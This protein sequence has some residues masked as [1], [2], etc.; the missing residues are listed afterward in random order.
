[1]KWL[2]LSFYMI[3]ETIKYF[4]LTYG[5]LG[6]DIRKGKKKYLIAIVPMIVVPVQI[7]FSMDT[8]EFRLIWGLLFLLAFFK[9][10]ILKKVQGFVIECMLIST[11]DLMIW[12]IYIVISGS[13]VD[14]NSFASQRLSEFICVILF[15]IFAFVLRKSRK[16]IG[17]YF[18]DLSIGYFC[19]LFV[20]LVGMAIMVSCIQVSLFDQTTEEIK[21]VSLM[22]SAVCMFLIILGCIS[23]VYMVYSKN[24]MQLI[25]ELDKESMQFQKKYYDKLLKQDEGT[26]RFRHDMAKHM[27]ALKVL[28]H[29]NKLEEVKEYVE[30]L[31][32]EYINNDIVHTGNAIANYFISATI[33]SLKEQGELEYR[34]LGRFPEPLKIS[35]SDMCI[36]LANA[37]DNAREALEQVK[38]E[39]KLFISIK[40]FQENVFITIANSAE[41]RDKPLLET[42]KED[43]SR[44]GYGTKNM[45]SVVEKYNGEIE[46][47]YEEGMFIVKIA[48]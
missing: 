39:R 12:S 44:H 3:M 22:A 28:C 24:R 4:L 13:D 37:L 27:N 23:F 10:R 38:G 9:G 29:E 11:I 48:I 31:T 45:K 41:F 18:Q 5:V 15:L 33:D 16:T 1:M 36:L 14:N 40:N 34:V 21:K 2:D 7:Y 35:S 42:V 47:K 26:R 17:N 32:S 20:I 30:E 46:W 25:N 43:K 6:F 8:L 19:V